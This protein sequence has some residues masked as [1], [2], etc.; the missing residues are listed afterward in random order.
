[1]LSTTHVHKQLIF[2]C[3]IEHYSVTIYAL[4]WSSPSAIYRGTVSD[5]QVRP[6]PSPGKIQVSPHPG[7]I[8]VLS[9]WLTSK[10]D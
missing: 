1:M 6:D 8:S 10:L 7:E 4:A 2:V 5:F 3:Y 9:N